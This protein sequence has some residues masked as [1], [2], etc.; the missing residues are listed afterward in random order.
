MKN[1]FFIFPP[2]PPGTFFKCLLKDSLDYWPPGFEGQFFLFPCIN[3]HQSLEG[4]FAASLCS[5]VNE[6]NRA[7]S[8]EDT[9]QLDLI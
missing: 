9:L 1:V 8:T 7:F 6:W 4:H 2:C 3:N 5:Q